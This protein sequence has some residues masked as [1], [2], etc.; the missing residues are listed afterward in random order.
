M[1]VSIKV[2]EALFL[3]QVNPVRNGG[4]KKEINFRN[5]DYHDDVITDGNT[6]RNQYQS[7]ETHARKRF[8]L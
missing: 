8:K 7:T 6:R 4:N 3:V 2:R 5:F 1:I